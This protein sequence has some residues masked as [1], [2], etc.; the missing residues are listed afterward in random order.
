MHVDC[1]CAFGCLFGRLHKDRRRRRN[2]RPRHNN[3]LSERESLA[4]EPIPLPSVG[5]ASFCAKPFAA[6]IEFGA[7]VVNGDQTFR[8]EMPPFGLSKHPLWAGAFCGLLTQLPR[9]HKLHDHKLTQSK[10]SVCSFARFFGRV[11]EAEGETVC[12]SVIGT[13]Q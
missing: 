1:G 13:G 10:A 6:Q 5:S 3:R 2:R 9:R 12:L 11:R 4:I 7:V 8:P